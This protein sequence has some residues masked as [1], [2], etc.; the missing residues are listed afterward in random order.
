[1]SLGIF[2]PFLWHYQTVWNQ[3]FFEV[4]IKLLLF[5][6]MFK[7]FQ[8]IKKNWYCIISQH[9]D[10]KKASNDMLTSSTPRTKWIPVNDWLSYSA[11]IHLLLLSF[12]IKVSSRAFSSLEYHSLKKIRI[13]FFS[14]C[15]FGAYIKIPSWNYGLWKFSIHQLF[16]RIT[17]LKYEGSIFEALRS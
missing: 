17:K 4:C 16:W 10:P 8:S 3:Y 1:M 2:P 5:Q 15:I 6:N 13:L 7:S 9:I 11:L 14:R 12:N